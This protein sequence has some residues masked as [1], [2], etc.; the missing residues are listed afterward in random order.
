MATI[1]ELQD[2]NAKALESLIDA[3]IDVKLAGID[4][5]G[6]DPDPDSGSGGG[7]GG[8]DPKPEI[9]DDDAY[10]IMKH[11]G[12]PD[13][14]KFGMES[15]KMYYESAVTS[16]GNPDK[17]KL[18]A[19]ARASKGL[20]I[21]D[22]ESWADPKNEKGRGFWRVDADGVEKYIQALRWYREAMPAGHRVA[23]YSILPVRNYFDAIADRDSERFKKWQGW[24]DEVVPIAK[25]VDL[26]FPSCYTFYDRQA[27]W[28]VYHQAQVEEAYR[29]SGG[30]KDVIPVVWPRFHPGNKGDIG[31]DFWR[32]QL[33]RSSELADGFLLWDDRRDDRTD[34]SKLGNWWD[35]TVQF[36]EIMP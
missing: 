24:N 13:L 33:E 28:K 26:F 34:F 22:I 1:E 11:H 15:V 4:L 10:V 9:E 5:G 21:L 17:A 14:A 29:I 19:A 2:L 23:L 32:M 36:A 12:Q 35:A 31:A 7:G 30:G 8:S 6:S 18:Q 16:G 25:Y 27:E 20:V 3:K